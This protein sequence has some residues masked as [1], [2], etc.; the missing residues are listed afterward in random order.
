MNNISINDIGRL[1]NDGSEIS[2]TAIEFSKEINNIY[3]IVD[4]L[5]MSWTGESAKRYTDNIES[6]KQDFIDFATKL[7]QY[8]ELINTVGRDYDKLENEI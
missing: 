1:I 4:Q 5:K 3:S 7:N 6:F 2:A 8:G